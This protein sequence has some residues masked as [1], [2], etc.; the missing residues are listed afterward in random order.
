M[1]SLLRYILENL[2]SHPEDIQIEQEE[3][4]DGKTLYKV[5]LN[6]EDK[7]FIIGKGGRNIKAIR[8]VIGALAVKEKRKVYIKI[9]D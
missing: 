7:G 2:A 1:D 3:V 4:E 9:L 5:T 8:D 6:D